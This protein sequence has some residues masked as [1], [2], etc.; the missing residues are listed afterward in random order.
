M[1]SRPLAALLFIC[2]S[3]LTLGQAAASP[4]DEPPSMRFEWVREGPADVCGDRC[5]DWIAATGPITADS[6]RDFDFFTDVRNVRG[7]TI[8]LDSGGGSVL[9]SLELGRRVRQLGMITTVGRTVKLPVQGAESQR[10]KLSPR[11]ECASMCVFVLLGG[12][13]RKVPAEAR[14]LVHQIW[15]GGKR[16]DA[17]AETY[18]AEEMVRIQ[19]DVGRI[20]RYTVEMGGDIELFELAMRIPPW[21]KLRA[22]TAPELRRMRLQ[23]NDTVAEAPTSGAV[24][25]ARANPAQ[26]ARAPENGWVAVEAATQRTLVRS[27]PLTIEGDEVGRFELSLSCSDKAGS[28]RIAYHETRLVGDADEA[29]ERLKEVVLWVA[30]E[31]FVLDIEASNLQAND[32][33][34]ESMA[35]GNLSSAVVKKLR[36]DPTVAM[37]V[38]TK[39]TENARTSI[40]LGGIGFP[41][42]FPQLAADC[43]KQR[44]AAADPAQ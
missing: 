12:V 6:A 43:Q 32:R 4:A 10:A 3:G 25:A 14:I 29:A 39:T 1:P 7:A 18:T 40:R 31:R 37:I 35:G 24:T 15:P 42:S 9:A 26:P 19:R 8:V 28:Y 44:H 33:E 17:S 36:E 38:G 22:L 16:Y 41:Q 27:H 21:E 20:A 13:Q 2:A 11:G 23:T 5:R 34:L 30:G